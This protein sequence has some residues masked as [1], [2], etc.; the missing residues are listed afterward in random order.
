MASASP[1]DLAF[2]LR[3]AAGTND[4]HRHLP[5]QI[6]VAGLVDHPKPASAQFPDDL[7]AADERSG[8]NGERLLFALLGRRRDLLEK[9]RQRTGRE[10][11][12]SRA[13]IPGAFGHTHPLSGPS[14]LPDRGNGPP[15]GPLTRTVVTPMSWFSR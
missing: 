8:G 4:L 9:G 1:G 15:D 6:P 5:A 7:E 3:D 13:A 12:R 14:R 11:R 10:A 2:L